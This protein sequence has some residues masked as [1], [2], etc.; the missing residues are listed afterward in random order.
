MTRGGMADLMLALVTLATNVTRPHLT[1]L[2]HHR[3]DH[4]Q[5]PGVIGNFLT[6]HCSVYHYRK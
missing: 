2:E 3:T 1:S 6:S 4:Y 5:S